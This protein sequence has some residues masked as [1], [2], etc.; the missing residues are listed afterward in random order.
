[1]DTI[2]TAGEYIG[3]AVAIMMLVAFAFSWI[4]DI[5]SKWA[6]K[7]QLDAISHA[8]SLTTLGDIASGGQGLTTQVTKDTLKSTP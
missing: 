4:R 1:M 6:Q 3:V 2:L 7:A 8:Q 5:M